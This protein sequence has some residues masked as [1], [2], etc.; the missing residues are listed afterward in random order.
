MS[1]AGR[2]SLLSIHSFNTPLNTSHINERIGELKD[3]RDCERAR[4]FILFNLSERIQYPD[5]VTV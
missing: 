1:E 2:T 4:A 5:E 3:I